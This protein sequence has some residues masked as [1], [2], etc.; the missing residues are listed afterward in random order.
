MYISRSNKES[1]DDSKNSYKD[2]IS[3]IEKIIDDIP[4]IRD[5]KQAFEARCNLFYFLEKIE[6]RDRYKVLRRLNLYFKMFSKIFIDNVVVAEHL[7]HCVLKDDKVRKNRTT[8]GS[9]EEQLSNLRIGTEDE[10]Q[11]LNAMLMLYFFT[12]AFYFDNGLLDN[13]NM[14]QINRQCKSMVYK[15]FTDVEDS[16]VEIWHIDETIRF[17]IIDKA[18]Q[19]K[20]KFPQ[21]IEAERFFHYAKMGEEIFKVIFTQKNYI[22]NLNQTFSLATKDA[23][24]LENI[25]KFLYSTNETI[26]SI[27]NKDVVEKFGVIVGSQEVRLFNTIL[28]S[29][30]PFLIKVNQDIGAMNNFNESMKMIRQDVREF[31]WFSNKKTNIDK[32][33]YG[34]MNKIFINIFKLYGALEL[35]QAS[36]HKSW[37]ESAFDNQV[38]WWLSE[39]LDIINLKQKENYDTS[40][41]I[42][43]LKYCLQQE[44]NQVEWKTSIYP[45]VEK[46]QGSQQRDTVRKIAET[47]L[48]MSNTNGGVIVVGKMDNNNLQKVPQEKR[49]KV[50]QVKQ[51]MFY[52]FISDLNDNDSDIDKFKLYLLDVLGQQTGKDTSIFN[53]ILTVKEEYLTHDKISVGIVLLEIQKA[54]S[55]LLIKKND[56][57][58]KY[59]VRANG[60]NEQ[61]DI[62]DIIQ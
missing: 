2:I 19:Y 18:F 9:F 48:A 44:N 42:S 3:E 56:G 38:Q 58:Y 10:K 34:W 16:N 62:N 20:D 55:I 40:N 45:L 37:K 13:E 35:I 27:N 6:E 1:M 33:R 39:C 24:R 5:K 12:I 52:D 36:N 54:D 50:L 8:K 31:S 47:I 22:N 30:I 28:L 4:K 26:N 57:S 7:Q 11:Y 59:P 23:N 15:I 53:S 49:H 21:S 17:I 61:G 43:Q 46:A 41:K 29:C 60:K 51:F 14:K 32:S 25:E